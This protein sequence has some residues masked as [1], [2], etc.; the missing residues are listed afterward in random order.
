ME[1]FVLSKKR[2][3]R[4]LGML[5]TSYKMICRPNYINTCYTFNKTENKYL[6]SKKKWSFQNFSAVLFINSIKVYSMRHD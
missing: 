2:F 4:A 1:R 3:K 5:I 6:I